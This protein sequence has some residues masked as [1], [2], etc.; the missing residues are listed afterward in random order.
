M[1][2]D[3]NIKSFSIRSKAICFTKSSEWLPNENRQTTLVVIGNGLNKMAFDK[4][5]KQCFA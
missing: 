2:K 1:S 4:K 5:L 3:K